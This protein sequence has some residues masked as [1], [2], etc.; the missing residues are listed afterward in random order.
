MYVVKVKNKF[1]TIFYVS[2]V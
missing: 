2:K 1:L